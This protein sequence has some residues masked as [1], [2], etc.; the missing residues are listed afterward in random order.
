MRCYRLCMTPTWHR[1]RYNIVLLFLVIIACAA[2]AVLPS[3]VA[4]GEWLYAGRHKHS[5]HWSH[6]HMHG[7]SETR[8][9]NSSG[10][11]RLTSHRLAHTTLS[12]IEF[13]SDAWRMHT[14]RCYFL[15]QKIIKFNEIPIYLMI[16]YTDTAQSTCKRIGDKIQWEHDIRCRGA[17][18]TKTNYK[19]ALNGRHTESQS[20]CD[21]LRPQSVS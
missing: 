1:W 13:Q 18:R 14:G 5:R 12:L 2:V 8:R 3:I 21:A 11:C 10:F 4:S 16:A 19:F 20:H 6:S 7:H 15:T 9:S 17:A